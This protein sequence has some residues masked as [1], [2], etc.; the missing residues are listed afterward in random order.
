MTRQELS[1]LLAL[2]ATTPPAELAEAR[3]RRMIDIQGQLRRKDL[4]PPLRGQLQTEVDRLES[5]D[6]LVFELEVIERVEGLFAQMSAALAEP[7]PDRASINLSLGRL[8]PLLARLTD[9]AQRRAFEER[10]TQV[11]DRLGLR[12][13]TT[14]SIPFEAPKAP[15]RPA[16]AKPAPSP[17]AVPV[18]EPKRVVPVAAPPPAVPASVVVEPLVAPPPRPVFAASGA[19]ARGTLMQ[20]TPGQIEGTLR[21]AGPVINFVARP[22]FLLGRRRASVD[23]VTAYLPDTAENQ[24]KTNTISRV[25]TTLF[26][27]E[28]HIWVQDG[29]PQ[30]DG[31]V[32]PSS[33]GTMVDGRAI[34][35][36]VP[37]DFTK[38]RRLR[39]G[40]FGYELA[41]LHLA[42]R[43]PDGPVATTDEDDSGQA[44]LRV[45][46][47]PLGCVRFVPVTCKEAAV[48]AV[49]MLSEATIGSGSLCAV[50]IDS[51]DLPPI[52]VRVHRWQEGFWLSVP[53][54]RDSVVALDGRRLEPGTAVP[55]QA[56]HELRLVDIS[57]EVSIS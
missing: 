27:R 33:N 42:A 21:R 5:A 22:R 20:L 10:R 13:P 35:A 16:E 49:W 50:R 31:S 36:A 48:A 30:P 14:P 47:R 3:A 24:Q 55:L 53:A 8:K 29:E 1:D 57:Y 28:D 40:H 52:A 38:E 25:N 56:V 9:Q 4:P 19:P 46:K 43:A 15:V 39:V 44:T 12:M 45:S 32:K 34:S 26:L 23:F 2:P 17:P 7:E 6:V 51:P 54:G 18:A 41:V 37:L 11:E